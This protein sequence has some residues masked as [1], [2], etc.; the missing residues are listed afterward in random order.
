[1][2]ETVERKTQDYSNVYEQTIAFSLP[3]DLYNLL[4]Q[5]PHEATCIL[6]WAIYKAIAFLD[7]EDIGSV[8]GFKNRPDTMVYRIKLNR[9]L[10]DY[11]NKFRGKKRVKFRYL[12]ERY[13]KELVENLF[14]AQ[15]LAKERIVKEEMLYLQKL[16]D[17]KEE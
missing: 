4:K 12:M 10:V 13:A 7:D 3:Y 9:E 14:Q 15:S 17:N 1:M 5:V 6:R 2:L 11:I 16:T 8:K